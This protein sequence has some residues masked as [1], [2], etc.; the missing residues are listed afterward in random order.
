MGDPLAWLDQFLESALPLLHKAEEEDRSDP[1]TMYWSVLVVTL[2]AAIGLRRARDSWRKRAIDEKQSADDF[3]TVGES[4]A[5][6][7]VV[8][9]RELAAA[10]AVL[11]W[12]DN[13]ADDCPVCAGGR[14]RHGGDDGV[15]ETGEI[16]HG[17]KCKLRAAKGTT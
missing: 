7:L 17:S 6:E 9:T 3:Q 15:W 5:T 2:R 10:Q 12:I 1:V 14:V 13:N 4:M 16:V 11:R 8:L